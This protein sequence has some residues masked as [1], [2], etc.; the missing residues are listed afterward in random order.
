MK[1]SKLKV[2]PVPKTMD[3]RMAKSV[4][5]SSVSLFKNFIQFKISQLLV[6][7]R[8]TS[9]TDKTVVKFHKQ[10]VGKPAQTE[11]VLLIN[12]KFSVVWVKSRWITPHRL[13]STQKVRKVELPVWVK[14]F[15]WSSQRSCHFFV[16]FNMTLYLNH[17]ECEWERMRRSPG[18]EWDNCECAEFRVG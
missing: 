3:S 8:K 18:C 4:W 15:F 13:V 17:P 7:G 16:K 5:L 6:A 14:T 2:S 9:K 10:K 11:K 1:I 12:K